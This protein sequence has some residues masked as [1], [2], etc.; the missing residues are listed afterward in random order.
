MTLK[1]GETLKKKKHLEGDRG[2][3]TSELIR[4]DFGQSE[5]PKA[6]PL[7]GGRGEEGGSPSVN[8]KRR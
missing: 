1:G 6:R 8:K 4:T 5:E 7:S 2:R 3:E